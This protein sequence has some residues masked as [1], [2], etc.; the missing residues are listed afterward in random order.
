[1][2]HYEV[3]AAVIEY[4]NKILCMQRGN[5][6]TAVT[7]EAVF[8]TVVS[9]LA[10]RFANDLLDVH[11]CGCCD[12]SHH[13]DKAC[14]AEGFAGNAGHGILTQHF[15]KDGIGDFITDFVGVSL[16]HGFAGK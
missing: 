9:D 3:V 2:K 5:D 15:I 4:D 14:G 6:C 12:L 16:C 7:V 13:A 11:L 10:N 1:M 8:C